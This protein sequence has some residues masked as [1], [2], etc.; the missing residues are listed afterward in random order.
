MFERTYYAIYYASNSGSGMDFF[1]AT[2][3]SIGGDIMTY[4]F[5]NTL[6]LDRRG[7]LKIRNNHTLTRTVLFPAT[8]FYTL[9]FHGTRSAHDIHTA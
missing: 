5:W 6:Q 8:I 9:A 1:L 3:V 7:F 4:G 2:I